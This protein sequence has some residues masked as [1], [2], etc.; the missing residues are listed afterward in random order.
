MEIDRSNQGENTVKINNLLA[1]V[2]HLVEQLE[3]EAEE[4][5]Q[6]FQQE[7]EAGEILTTESQSFGQ[8]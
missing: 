2:Y 3:Q 7:L 4:N 5:R 1:E 8:K 6:R